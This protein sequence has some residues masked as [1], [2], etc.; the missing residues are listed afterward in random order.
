VTSVDPLLSVIQRSADDIRR[1]SSAG[2]LV[3]R[4]SA[5]GEG[6]TDIPHW[7]TVDVENGLKATCSNCHF[8]TKYLLPCR[9]IMAVNLQALHLDAF[10]D[11]QCHPRWR[12]D[13]DH[14]QP[15]Q[16]ASAAAASTASTV[17]IP[18]DSAA[19]A[20]G[21]SDDG[22]PEYGKSDDVEYLNSRAEFDWVCGM[23]RPNGADAW[24]QF[25]T[26]LR[27]YGERVASDKPVEVSQA[28][29]RKRKVVHLVH[30]RVHMLV[31]HLV[32]HPVA[33]LV[34]ISV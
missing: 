19:D 29:K 28:A 22:G 13:G 9:H 2:W 11:K 6:V 24:K 7:V 23:V 16:P 20:D 14:Q 18:I 10:Q 34:H 31:Y 1:A 21:L 26:W 25:R 5:V 17:D 30:N 32:A 27:E 15:Q 3:T 12:L 33:N 4:K 8:S